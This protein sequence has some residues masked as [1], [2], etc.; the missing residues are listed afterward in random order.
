MSTDGWLPIGDAV[1]D[2]WTVL[3]RDWQSVLIGTAIVAL[4]VLFELQIPW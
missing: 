2:R 4:V 3:E 1:T